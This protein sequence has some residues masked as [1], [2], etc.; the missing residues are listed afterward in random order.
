[1]SAGGRALY[2][3]A[4]AIIE[5]PAQAGPPVPVAAKGDAGRALFSRR[6][7]PE[8][9]KSPGFFRGV[10]FGEEAFS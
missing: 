6:V 10:F 2:P 8:K 3:A 9:T 5:T 7:P 1:M 4:A